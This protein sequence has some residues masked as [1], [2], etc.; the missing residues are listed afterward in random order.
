MMDKEEIKRLAADP[1]F[2]SGIYNYCDRWCERCAFTSR[3]MNFAMTERQFS[4]PE[5]RDIQNKAFW[6]KLGEIFHTTLEMVKEMAEEQGIDLDSIDIEDEET[7]ERYENHECSRAA[8]AYT[9]MVDTWFESA[10]G[11]F[12]QK[13]DELNQKLQA[14]IP[15]D[16]PAAEAEQLRD[17]VDIIRWYQYQ[18]YV[19]TIRA[20]RGTLEDELEILEGFPKDSD[21]SAKVALIG[22]DRSLGAWG[23][24]LT[25]LPDRE[26]ETLEILVHLER[27]RR[28]LERDFPDARDFVRPGFDEP[29]SQGV[30]ALLSGRNEDA[31]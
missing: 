12:E 20:V 23:R 29:R 1:R 7:R 21:G 22:I 5:S 28:N 14:E 30:D 25:H 10:A 17:I 31:E 16:D 6:E 8:K 24:M 2:I 19:K 27:L 15:E 13:E 11:L 18:I 3:C 26:D 4:D 9:G